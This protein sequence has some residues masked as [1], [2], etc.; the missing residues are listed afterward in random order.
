MKLTGIFAAIATPF[1]H[2]GAI[3]KTKV[4]HNLDKW[5]QTALSGYVIAS[6]SGEGVLLSPDERGELWK[7]SAQYAGPDKMLIADTSEESVRGTVALAE[8]AAGAGFHAVLCGVPHFYRSM[9]Y[10]PETQALYFRA[11]ADRS[12]L[13]VILHNAPQTTGVD[14]APETAGLLSQHPNIVGVVETGTPAIRIRQIAEAAAAG[15]AILAGTGSSVLDALDAGAQGAVLPIASAAPYSAIALWEAFRTREKEAALDWQQR[16]SH[17]S[18]LVTDLY[19]VAGL[20][21]AMNG[22]G[23]YGG[24]PRLPLSGLAA[25]ARLEIEAAFHDLKG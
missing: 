25:P 15:F 20:K 10:G 9:M 16:L 17:A 21:H 4:Q 22:N 24:P 19:G 13:P 12:P 2:E 1:D 7:L 8:A 14:L 3:Y 6:G 18:I 5:N 23:F 11:V